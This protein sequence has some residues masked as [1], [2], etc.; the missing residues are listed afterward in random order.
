MPVIYKAR[1]ASIPN[2]EGKKL[3]HPQAV[4]HPMAAI[5]TTAVVVPVVAMMN[6][7]HWDDELATSD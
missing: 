2:K 3:Y 4:R 5:P 1:K 6:S 7:I